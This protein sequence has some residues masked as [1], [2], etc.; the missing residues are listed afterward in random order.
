MVCSQLLCTSN[1]IS[2]KEVPW[3]L[4]LIV[5]HEVYFDALYKCLEEVDLDNLLSFYIGNQP[6]PQ[7]QLGM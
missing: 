5:Y 6:G 1:S 4:S 7:C 3:V 2:N